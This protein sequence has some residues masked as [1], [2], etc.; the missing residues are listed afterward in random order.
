MFGERS[1]HTIVWENIRSTNCL[2]KCKVKQLSENIKQKNCFGKF[3]MSQLF[4][5]SPRGQ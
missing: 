3:L 1:H 4:A 2:E 5:T